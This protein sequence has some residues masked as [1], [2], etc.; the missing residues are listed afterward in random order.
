MSLIEASNIVMYYYP[1][2]FFVMIYLKRDDTKEKRIIKHEI[3]IK[4]TFSK[5]E[6]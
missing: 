5:Y 3:K 1:T 2:R 4:F 6:D